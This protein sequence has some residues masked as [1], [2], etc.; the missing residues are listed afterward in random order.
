MFEN[1][2]ALGADFQALVAGGSALF[3]ALFAV[4]G[5]WSGDSL[6]IASV[7]KVAESAETLAVGRG[8]ANQV[9][10]AS[11]DPLGEALVAS[12]HLASNDNWAGTADSVKLWD[13]RDRGGKGQQN[14]D[15][16]HHGDIGF[17]LAGWFAT[18]E[19]LW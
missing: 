5:S 17:K 2:S 14:D 19:V 8:V 12:S 16:L 4:F 6:G 18:L 1:D 10:L 13:G 15:K 11:G 9:P 7:N 3:N